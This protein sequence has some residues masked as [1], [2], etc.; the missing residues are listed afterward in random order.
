MFRQFI[1]TL[2]RYY[3]TVILPN[4]LF[5]DNN[6]LTLDEKRYFVS[7]IIAKPEA[8]R[9][10]EK[11]IRWKVGIKTRAAMRSVDDRETLKLK[12]QAYAFGEQTIDFQNFWNEVHRVD[13]ETEAKEKEEKD[14]KVRFR[15]FGND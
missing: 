9:L 4:S 1:D 5:E 7:N 8:R 13:A 15:Y 11:Y 10:L 14:E 3:R 6:A 2:R 12:E